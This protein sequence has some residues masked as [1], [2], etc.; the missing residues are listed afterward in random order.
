MTLEAW[1]ED[2]EAVIDAMGLERVP[3]LGI[4]QGANR[5]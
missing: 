5:P 1:V 3:L 4:S 2:L